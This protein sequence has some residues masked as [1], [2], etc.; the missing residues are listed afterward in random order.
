MGTFQRRRAYK[1]ERSEGRT[2]SRIG[3]V[4][5]WAAMIAAAATGGIAIFG[6]ALGESDIRSLIAGLLSAFG[7][8]LIGYGCRKFFSDLVG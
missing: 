4:V 2:V 7:A 8:V 6:A 3:V 5:Y 1:Q